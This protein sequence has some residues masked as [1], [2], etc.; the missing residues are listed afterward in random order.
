MTQILD[1]QP[2]HVI[3]P[4]LWKSTL[5]TPEKADACGLVMNPNGSGVLPPIMGGASFS[6]YLENKLLDH[7]FNDA[8]Y[9]APTP[10]LGLWTAALTDSSTGSAGSE[11]TYGGY[12]RLA[13]S[14]SDMGAASG[15]SKT[16]SGAALTFAACSSSSSVI[17]Y[18]GITDAS[19]TGA[20]N[21][22]VWGTATSTTISTTQTPATIASSGLV[23][24]LD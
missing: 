20:G 19:G 3:K 6:D 21:M 18:W 4:N 22:L 9:T 12:A 23:V 2:G 17:T 10:Y 14:T 13:I 15:G 16:N 1:L 24:T 7:I 11:A 8:S 5:W